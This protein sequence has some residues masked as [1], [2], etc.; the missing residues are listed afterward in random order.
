MSWAFLLVPCPATEKWTK[1]PL[2]YNQTFK[3]R[4]QVLVPI[5]GWL[6]EQLVFIRCCL[7]RGVC[8]TTAA[9]STQIYTPSSSPLIWST[10]IYTRRGRWNLTP[11]RVHETGSRYEYHFLHRFIAILTRWTEIN[12]C[13]CNASDHYNVKVLLLVATGGQILHHFWVFGIVVVKAWSIWGPKSPQ[14]APRNRWRPGACRKNIF[15]ID[16]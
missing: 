3:L 8:P 11:W 4:L 6:I 9:I 14:V 10:I 1:L 13:T 12:P 2:H 7:F 15:A 16:R 5:D